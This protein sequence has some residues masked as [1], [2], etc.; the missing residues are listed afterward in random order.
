ME[1]TNKIGKTYISAKALSMDLRTSAVE[2]IVKND[3]DII[4]GYFGGK[5]SNI[6]KAVGSLAEPI[7]N[8][9]MATS[10]YRTFD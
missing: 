6:S 4:S 9:Y 5:F 8:K 2:E 10:A 3:S 1:R 7:L